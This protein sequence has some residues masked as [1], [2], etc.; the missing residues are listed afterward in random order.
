M[1]VLLLEDQLSYG[2]EIAKAVRD[3]GHECSWGKT[4]AEGV[5]LAGSYQWDAALLDHDLPNDE[6]GMDNPETGVLVAKKLLDRRPDCAI[7]GISAV[8]SN[9]EHLEAC[10]AFLSLPKNA[11]LWPEVLPRV[12][13]SCHRWMRAMQ[14]IHRACWEPGIADKLQSYYPNH[15]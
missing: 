5:Y 14:L 13:A 7:V 9:N 10:G 15:E 1:K 11:I 2:M 6:G 3:L 4:L 8:E 12:L